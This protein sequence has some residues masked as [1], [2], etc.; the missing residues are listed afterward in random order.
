MNANTNWDET[1]INNSTITSKYIYPDSLKNNSPDDANIFSLYHQNI[2]SLTKHNDEFLNYLSYQNIN[3]DCIILSETFLNDH[4]KN[5]YSL[6]GFNGNHLVRSNKRGG[7]VS[8]FVRNDI[9]EYPKI[10]YSLINDH[11]EALVVC[12]ENKSS[13]IAVVGLYRPPNGSKNEFINSLE[14]IIQTHLRNTKMI[15]AGDFNIDLC[16]HGPS[17]GNNSLS[18]A[19]MSNGLINY[20]TIPTRPNNVENRNP[21]LLD[22]VWGNLDCEINSFVIKTDI[23]DHYSCLVRFNVNKTS[24]LTTVKYR[25]DNENCRRV[26][27]DKVN[28]IDFSFIQNEQFSIDSKF[29]IFLNS[30]NTCYNDSFPIKT[31]QLGPKRIQNPW[32]TPG[33]KNSINQ[34][35]K[36]YRNYKE[37]II[38]FQLYTNF[39]KQLKIVLKKAKKKYYVDKFNDVHNDPKKTWGLINRLINKNK[40]GINNIKE[41]NINGI[42]INKQKEIADELNNHFTTIGKQNAANKL[43]NQ[44]AFETY[45]RHCGSRF[46]FKDISSQEVKAVI[47]GQ[48]NKACDITTIPNNILKLIADIISSPLKDLFNASFHTG[49]FP[50][51][52]KITRV[53]P[54]HKKG[55]KSSPLNYRPI[56]ITHNISKIFEKLILMQI[57]EYLSS[58]NLLNDYQFGFRKG[59]S[60]SDA[61]L[62]LTEKIYENIERKESSLLLLLDLTKAFDSIDHD[63]LIKK[64]KM[65]GIEGSPLQWFRSYLTSRPQFVKLGDIQSKPSLLTTGVPQGS[66]LGPLLFTLYTNDLFNSHDSFSICFADDISILITDKNHDTLSQK[67]VIALNKIMT[68]I[69]SNKLSLNV[70]KT[71]YLIISNKSIKED[72]KINFNQVELQRVSIAKIL[73]VIFDD[74]LT[75]KEHI[76]Q[77]VNK[78]VKYMYILVKLAKSIPLYI[79]KNIYYAHVHSQLLY[80]LPI[81]GIARNYVINPVIIMQKRFIRLLSA[82]LLYDH[83]QPL[84]KKLKILQFHQLLNLSLLKEQHKIMN[85]KTCNYLTNNFRNNQTRRDINLRN[86]LH[87][88]PPFYRLEKARQAVTYRS[89]KLLNDLPT[90][91]KNIKSLKAF[92][93]KI[94]KYYLNQY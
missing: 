94:K 67:A 34:K 60:T 65:M 87:I 40:S 35:H 80:C 52:F 12:I 73:G 88:N 54:I 46:S 25:I 55:D 3:L 79:L 2:R 8:I 47:A 90:D 4:N 45:L 15:I 31:K 1:L 93:R 64:M 28:N 11:I 83:T 24:Y 58:N 7:G 44:T 78:L 38:P 70:E 9:C 16:N 62:C 75:F 27:V 66:I 77:L 21:T 5:M 6:P 85:N 19:M 22:H 49:I 17:T 37:G 43:P 32:L 10:I 69:I 42:T 39:D 48:K 76:N 63:I 51:V 41:L 20:I 13:K 81:Y 74:K 23:S 14:S 30:L 33:L 68:W 91:I 71:S 18:N 61:L 50:H 26:F 82:S 92:T 59:R 36:L 72:F 89:A 84:F 57:T 53:T 86:N 56:S 29:N